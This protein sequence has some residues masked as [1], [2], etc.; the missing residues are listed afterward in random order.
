M[1][2]RLAVVKRVR[3]RLAT[4]LNDLGGAENLSYQEQVI[5]KRL[6]WLE[7]LCE[8]VE[9]QIAEGNTDADVGKYTQQIN[10]IIGIGRALGLK[11]RAKD[12]PSLQDYLRERAAEQAE[13]NGHGADAD[14]EPEAF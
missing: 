2:N 9:R 8:Q 13:H 7:A 3:D 11:R 4:L 14:S 6:V 5:A 10:T 1:D 12:V